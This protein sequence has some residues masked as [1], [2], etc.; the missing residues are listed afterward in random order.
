[1][2]VWGGGGVMDGGW[3]G[4]ACLKLERTNA[5]F[6]TTRWTL[7]GRLREGTEAEQREAEAEIACVYWPPVYGA[8]R[9]MG[10]GREEASELAQAFF[11]EVMIRRGLPDSAD[12]GRGRMRTLVLSALRNFLIDQH[13]RAATERSGAGVDLGMLEREDEFLTDAS[14]Q[15]PDEVF[16][17]RWAISLVERSLRRCEEHCVATG[18]SRNWEAFAA[19]VVLPA[20][21]G[22]QPASL[23]DLA[24]RLGFENRADAAAAVQTVK[25]RVTIILRELLAEETLTE[26]HA[27]EDFRYVVGLLGSGVGRPS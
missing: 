22:C 20:T 2:L 17:R 7:L 16:D 5:A 23:D 6:S 3:T 26:E 9:R 11:A 19:R 18:K 1:M 25:R 13:R 24:A 12:V 15:T 8:L 21:G 27:E 14:G 4:D 10:R